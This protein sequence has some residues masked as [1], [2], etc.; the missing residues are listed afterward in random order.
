[1]SRFFMIIITT[2]GLTFAS[3]TLNAQ[4]NIFSNV[5]AQMDPAAKQQFFANLGELNALDPLTPVNRFDELA[6]LIEDLKSGKLNIQV[7][8]SYLDLIL[9]STEEVD[10]GTDPLELALLQEFFDLYLDSIK[11]QNPKWNGGYFAGIP[12]VHTGQML[13]QDTLRNTGNNTVSNGTGDQGSVFEQLF[14]NMN[15]PLLEMAFGT[16]SADLKYYNKAYS[17]N[18]KVIRFGSVLGYDTNITPHPW[19]GIFGLYPLEASWHVEA[20]WMKNPEAMGLLNQEIRAVD[21]PD[22]YSPLSFNGDFNI[23]ITPYF[24]KFPNM[25]MRIFTSLGME[26]GIYA[27]AHKD[28]N[29]PK[30]SNNQG[31]TT[32]FGPQIGLGFAFTMGPLVMYS[33]NTLAHGSIYS[34]PDQVHPTYKYHNLRFEAGIRYGK[35]VNVRYTRG[36]ASW[37]PNGNRMA[38][39]K[40]QVTIGLILPE[41]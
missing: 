34:G 1:M 14:D 36:T 17:A 35:V 10:V 31:F 21:N 39:V 15:F 4:W 18:A 29:P 13:L 38:T 11:L 32:G 26:F 40:N 22:E 9:A 8:S 25:P 23:L 19:Q 12:N 37:Q 2:L 6:R 20:S 16:Q 7:D 27:P 41:L 28:Y 5:F 3:F 24:I 33:H 30:T